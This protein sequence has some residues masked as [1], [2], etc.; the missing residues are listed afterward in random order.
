[1]TAASCNLSGSEL[2]PASSE[3]RQ[4]NA[5]PTAV[6]TAHGATRRRS[7]TTTIVYAAGS[8]PAIANAAVSDPTNGRATK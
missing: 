1:M 5:K 3:T 2:P 8:A 4:A 6:S 7:T